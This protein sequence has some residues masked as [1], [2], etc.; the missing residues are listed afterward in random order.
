MTL[1]FLDWVVLVLYLALAAGMGLLLAGKNTSLGDYLFGSGGMPWFAVGISLIA[2]SVSAS[3]FL[4]NPAD[5]FANDMTYLMLNVGTFIGIIVIW[6]VFIPRF[7]AAKVKSAYEILENRFDRRVRLLAAGFFSLHLILRTG[8][9]L[10]G[11]SLVLAPMLGITV[12][13]AILLSS[14]L[15]L[16]Y[17][18]FGGI[19]AVIWTDVMQ[20]MVL[21]GGGIAVLFLIANAV[22]GW[23]VLTTR[24]AELGKTRWYDFTIDPKSARNFLSAALIYS[25]FEVAIRGCDQQFL[26]R[27]MSCKS[28]EDA[29]RSSLLSAVLGLGIGFLFYWVGAALAVYYAPGGVAALAPD[30]AADS[31]F[32]HFI[33]HVLPAGFTGLLVAAI[34]A[35]AMS[36]LDSAITA[37]SN[38]T[39]VDFL[40]EKAEGHSAVRKARY[41]VIIWGVLG[42]GAAL[43]AAN[44]DKSLLTKALFFT[45]LF[46]GPL[47]GMFLLAFYAPRVSSRA[48]FWG[49]VLG[50]LSLLP[51]SKLFFWPTWKPIYSFSWPWNPLISLSGTIIS[52]LLLSLLFKREVKNG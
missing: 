34:F 36:S 49:A 51:F 8:I 20:F 1:E 21:F 3:T 27:Y 44:G 14:L 17:T 22:G 6:K 48:A 38:T 15:A 16:L 37:L 47:L 29:N 41:W 42:V 52:A 32:P 30:T 18:W 5:V 4:G 23:D 43:L 25:V 35:A 24:A 19:K 45:S 12:A 7:R 40:G 46:T 11:P 28:V 13:Q 31:V 26:Q 9:L 50:M 39:V 2:T 10:Y 33:L